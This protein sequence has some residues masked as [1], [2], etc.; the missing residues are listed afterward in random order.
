MD[1]EELESRNFAK[2]VEGEALDLDK[3]LEK[4]ILERAR[5]AGNCFAFIKYL[6][7]ICS[8]MN[9]EQGA[10][11]Q[12]ESTSTYDY[13]QAV[14]TAAD[15]D[16]DDLMAHIEASR[17]QALSLIAEKRRQK[18]EE[19]RKAQEAE[20]A[21]VGP[22]EPTVVTSKH[23][24]IAIME[25][26]VIEEGD[27]LRSVSQGIDDILESIADAPMDV[28]EDGADAESADEHSAKETRRKRVVAITE[29]ED[30]DEDDQ[31]AF[32]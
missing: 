10:P 12:Q 18:E 25:E 5:E 11:P 21:R 15:D 27:S 24:Q 2:A 8:W 9:A 1:E 26:K 31:F 4:A 14:A 13:S 28:N 20:L 6:L 30:D 29:E 17:E 16:D 19:Q 7:I 32:M 22:S 3:E 23:S